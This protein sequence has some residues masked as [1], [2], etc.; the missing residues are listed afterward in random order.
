VN[1]SVSVAVVGA[2]GYGGAELVGL[3][4]K[5][6]TFSLDYITSRSFAGEPFTSVHPRFEDRVNLVCEEIEP[7]RLSEHD[8][9]FFALPHATSM[10]YIHELD[11]SETRV[12]DLAADYRL[13]SPERFEE[14]YGEEHA[15]PEG[16][17]EAVYGLTEYFQ[18]DVAGADLVACP[19][20]YPT[21]SLV[22][23]YPL[24]EEGLLPNNFYID[25]KS[26]VS[27]AGRKASSANTFV[28]CND[29]IRP[30]SVAEHRHGPEIGAV[31]GTTGSRPNFTFVPHINSMDHGIEAALYLT[32]SSEQD[33]RRIVECI[34]DRADRHQ[35]F[36]Y[37]EEPP[38]VKPVVKTPYCDLSVVRDGPRVVVFSTLDNLWKG[39][40]SQAVQN[41]NLMLD[42]PLGEGLL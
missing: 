31:L 29:T 5:H 41:A 3:L 10:N 16:Y 22:P 17:D 25:A 15:D 28:N 35:F 39:A 18:D 11:C 20:C 38:G 14:V 42:R 9:A 12:V 7:E 8:L 13:P 40:S 1:S 26:G 34:R 4:S 21:S 37:F 6:P 36:R 27:G 32:S 24:A 23:L 2:T 30:Y 19:G 33:A